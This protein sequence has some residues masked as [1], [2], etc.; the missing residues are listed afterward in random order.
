M[1]GRLLS[2]SSNSTRYG[3]WNVWKSEWK[4]S[5]LHEANLRSLDV[6]YDE[7]LLVPSDLAASPLQPHAACHAG[8]LPPMSQILYQTLLLDNADLA[9]AA[10][11]VAS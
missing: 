11:S 1:S 2:N 7:G 4:C 3:D 5:L 10:S 9:R 6:W 8:Y